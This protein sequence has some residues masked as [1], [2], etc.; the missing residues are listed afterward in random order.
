LDQVHESTVDSIV[1]LYPSFPDL[2]LSHSADGRHILFDLKHGSDTPVILKRDKLSM[3]AS[4]GWI[5]GLQS[6]VVQEDRNKVGLQPLRNINENLRSYAEHEGDALT[7][8]VSL[9][10]P[11]LL[12]HG[13]EGELHMVNA[14]WRMV[15]ATKAKILYQV[16]AHVHYDEQEQKF[17]LI[18]NYQPVQLNFSKANKSD[19]MYPT[20]Q[21]LLTPRWNCN[22]EAASWYA[23]AFHTVLRVENLD[24]MGR[25]ES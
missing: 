8:G 2:V 21:E 23:T 10:H 6:L 11:F 16:L 12:T 19:N 9:F 13:R 17:L 7:A 1:P 18:E 15:T 20:E 25:R 3:V 5:E 4:G 24:F 14:A 22:L